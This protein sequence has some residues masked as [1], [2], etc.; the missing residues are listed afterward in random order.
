MGV[1]R[2]TNNQKPQ[3]RHCAQ[4]DNQESEMFATVANPLKGLLSFFVVTLTLIQ[5]NSPTVASAFEA[6][7]FLYTHGV[8][9]SIT[10]PRAGFKCCANLWTKF[11]E[12]IGV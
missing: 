5:R 12:D 2:L 4:K 3:K 10:M 6:A 1:A 11:A 9:F 7:E 8:Y